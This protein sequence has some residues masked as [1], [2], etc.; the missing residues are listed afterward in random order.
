[1]QVDATFAGLNNVG[2]LIINYKPSAYK[3]ILSAAN[4]RF[5]KIFFVILISSPIMI[6]SKSYH[7]KHCAQVKVIFYFTFVKEFLVPL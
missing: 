4:T 5:F 2:A 3:M 6:G 7:N 1:M